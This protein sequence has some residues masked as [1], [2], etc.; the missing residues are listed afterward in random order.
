MH[1]LL[2]IA[3]TAHAADRVEAADSLA[4]GSTGVGNPHVIGAVAANPAVP[5]TI[6]TYD[7]SLAGSYGQRGLH[8]HVGA[9][10]TETS[11]IALGLVYSGD[12]FNPPLTPRELPG[13]T[14]P[15]TE[16]TNL[17]Q[18][19]DIAMSAAIPFWERR[20]SVGIGGSVSFFNHERTGKGT[21][22]NMTAGLAFKP[23]ERVI[24]GLSGRNFLPISDPT[25]DRP[26]ELMGGL[27]T[28]KTGTF[29][30]A[31]DGGARLDAANP[32]LLAAGLEGNPSELAVLR[33]GWRL[34]EGVNHVAIGAGAGTPEA[35]IDFGM[36]VPTN[37]LAK[38][39]DWTFQLSIRIAG[40]DLDRITPDG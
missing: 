32:L 21:T 24:I 9:I 12:R 38:P 40:P 35:A 25:F 36:Q 30:L 22:G 6:D 8:W 13:W 10:D 29:G 26:L 33:A 28:G 23:D 5:G 20:I 7:F 2:A 39:A 17:K 3:A 34:E 19:H 14:I 31:V 11:P 37:A 15:G 16:L 27:W 4:M 1:L 18:N